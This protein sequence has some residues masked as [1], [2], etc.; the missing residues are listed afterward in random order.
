VRHVKTTRLEAFSDGVLAIIIT[1]MVLELYKPVGPTWHDLNG[2][3]A[4]SF[5][6]Y[7]LSFVYVGIYWNNHHHLMH[8]NDRV[9][10]GI[11]W[12][13]MALLFFLSL[14]P[15]TTA[16]MDDENFASAP[17]IVYGLGL[18]ANSIAYGILVRTI[19]HAQG[20]DGPVRQ[21]FGNDLKG[22]ISTGLYIVGLVITIWWAPVGIAFYV[23]VAIMWV[24][25]DRRVERVIERLGIPDDSA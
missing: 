9:T 7:L 6:T 1:I 2:D 20:V 13:N 8:L 22:N 23:I 21:A 4:R 24:V 3:V 15:A 19:M 10:G 18:L 12:A 16:W 14:T 5:L 11:L 17:T 25:P